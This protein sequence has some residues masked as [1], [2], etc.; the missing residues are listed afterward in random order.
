MAN[1]CSNRLKVSG[2]SR[3]MKKFFE[4]LNSGGNDIFQMS[5]FLPCPEELSDFQSPN[6]FCP[7]SKIDVDDENGKLKTILLDKQGRTEVEF[8]TYISDLEDKYGYSDCDQWLD[9]NWGC[10]YDVKY[11]VTISKSKQ[12]YSVTYDTRW[13]PN[14]EFIEYLHEEFSR[15]SFILDYCESEECFAGTVTITPYHYDDME[16]PFNHACFNLNLDSKKYIFNNEFANVFWAEAIG[17]DWINS[18]AKSGL[19][20]ETVEN[21]D[22]V[23][24]FF[25]LIPSIW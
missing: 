1:T 19:T 5:K 6:I 11:P 21:W 23:L 8:N 14:I 15:L 12:Y 13:S 7:V 9:N 3:S 17:E 22:T 2:S 4:C 16:K 24:R 25:C 18:L 10:D 20:M